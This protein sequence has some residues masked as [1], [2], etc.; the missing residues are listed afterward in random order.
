MTVLK[1][2]IIVIMI[3]I[4]TSCGVN[5]SKNDENLVAFHAYNDLGRQIFTINFD[6]PANSLVQITNN[7]H[8]NV[9]PLFSH[10]KKYNLYSDN[11]L[12][13][14]NNYAQWI[15]DFSEK[16][17]HLL[18]VVD[19]PY[20]IAYGRIKIWNPGDSKIYFGDIPGAWAAYD[21]YEYALDSKIMK[22]LTQDFQ[23]VYWPVGFLDP[24]TMIIYFGDQNVDPGLYKMDLSGNVL[25]KIENPYFQRKIINGVVKSG[26]RT[27]YYSSEL[28]KF[29]ISM[30]V[31]DSDG[32]KIIATDLSGSYYEEFTDGNYLDDF[33]VY[34]PDNNFIIFMRKPIGDHL[35]EHSKIMY[36]DLSDGTSKVLI[37]EDMFP[38]LYGFTCPT[39]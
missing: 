14:H 17:S 6:D 3:S 18:E 16:G 30:I 12:A 34:G 4:V 33:P 26:P 27:Y 9:E 5:D 31:E 15:Y 37:D 36:F 29:L 24:D 19:F 25:D 35:N 1:Y 7:D 11:K 10:D 28:K 13:E 23:E 39:F 22:S 38:N 8:Q 2:F 20:T 32:Y 21:I